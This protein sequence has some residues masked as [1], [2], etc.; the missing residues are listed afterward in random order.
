MQLNSPSLKGLLKHLESQGRASDFRTRKSIYDLKGLNKRL[1][2]YRGA[3]SQNFAL[4]N[5]I[6][7]ED[8]TDVRLMKS[9]PGQKHVF[10]VPGGS[11]HTGKGDPITAQETAV[12][13]T[14]QD[15]TPYAPT[16]GNIANITSSLTGNYSV[17]PE[18][19]RQAGYQAQGGGLFHISS[20]QMVPGINYE[21]GSS[22]ILGDPNALQSW[23]TS[24]GRTS[25]TQTP[26]EAAGQPPPQA[27][28]F[29]VTPRPPQMTT[30]AL[31]NQV[32]VGVQGVNPLGINA[33][34]QVNQAAN[35]PIPG[36]IQGAVTP[37][38]R[39]LIDIANSRPD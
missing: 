32:P 19:L 15:Y 16:G 38:P 12:K 9:K 29:G 8:E 33:P 30:D 35:P 2:P 27:G 3:E 14:V 37:Q 7:R 31:G 4:G 17:G 13:K 18:Q 5:I 21:P 39:T 26:A 20:G 36:A 34:P 25:T 22:Q 6:K 10:D 1:G 28:D 24:L 11:F 23:L